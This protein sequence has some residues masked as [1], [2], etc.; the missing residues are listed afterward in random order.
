MPE[1]T[2]SDRPCDRVRSLRP[3]ASWEWA[4]L[5]GNGTHGAL[6]FGDPRAE[7]IIVNHERLY[8]PREHPG[9]P[10]DVAPYLPTLRHIV[11]EDG[12]AEG[13]V[14]L[15]TRACE[16]GLAPPRGNPAFHPAFSLRVATRLQG[17]VSHYR[18]ETDFRTGEV[19]VG[20]QDCRR[21]FQ[22][23]LFVSRDLDSV[24]LDL[25]CVGGA[26]FSCELTLHHGDHHGL[27]RPEIRARAQ[28][29]TTTVAY[30][31][32]TGGYD[33]AVR[34]AATDGRTEV[35]GD[36]IRIARARRALLLLRVRPWSAR[37]G[38]DARALLRSLVASPPSY[39]G[40]LQRHR[41]FHTR[42]YDRVAID[43]GGRRADREADIESLIGRC[44]RDGS[45]ALALLEKLYNAGRYM[46]LCCFGALPPNLQGVW[47]GTW[48]SPWGG[49]YVWDTNLQ[50]AIASALSCNMQE[51]WGAYVALIEGVVPFWKDNARRIGGCR[52][53]FA[54][55]A[56]CPGIHADGAEKHTY[57][58]WSWMFGA[59][60]AGWQ[61][62]LFYDG[63]L[64]TGDLEYLRK[65]VVPLLLE[66]AAFYEDWLFLD[67]T[68]RYR[69]S[70]ACS[71]EV[72]F[73][74]NPTFEIAVA[75]DVLSLLPESVAALRRAGVNEGL[76]TPAELR[77]WRA[78]RRKLPE[79]RINDAAHTAGP[80]DTRGYYI[81]RAPVPLEADGALKEFAIPNHREV[82]AHRHFSHLYPV[83]VSREFDPER[84][85]GLW[86]AAEI[87]LEK[88]LSHWVRGPR[89]NGATHGRMH[90]ALCA[91]EFG[92][93]D[94]AWEVLTTLATRGVV[95][96]SLMM[97]H[98]DDHRVFNVDG[99]GALPEVVN[100]MLVFA[101]PG[102]IRLLP[103]LPAQLP[104]GSVQGLRLRGRIELKR[105]EWDLHAGVIEAVVVS[106]VAQ[107]VTLS[108]GVPHG[109]SGIE[110]RRTDARST[111]AKPAGPRWRLK[112]NPGEDVAVRVQ[113]DRV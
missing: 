55:G 54:S 81:D 27:V 109:V 4:M 106:D 64:Y 98:F 90:A 95:F 82:Y 29:L 80:P 35:R 108:V 75:R 22:R 50:L 20:F 69:F 25:A 96:P 34:V 89:G 76:P 16:K 91:L 68:G 39:E 112:L 102:E 21:S 111:K 31:H 61:A 5:S 74:D 2:G 23:R 104:R 1:T 43:L 86:R 79:Y 92:R 26:G 103:G 19:T 7:T 73:A 105:L 85:P 24:V 28:G 53:V 84:T 45:L 41:A 11:R 100:R 87:A 47:S 44:E 93:G 83:F 110:T 36:R 113:L 99:N 14:F 52:G 67:D 59:G 57:G 12:Y 107:R 71:P 60:Y 40:L 88:R 49:G 13:L 63:W 94:V 58:H 33:G 38:S 46:S 32:G 65:H 101:R 70:P 72:G 8:L 30:L 48:D 37:Q 18:R 56:Y 97:S 78:M 17:E 62:R 15:D 10:L 66:V 51:L 6:V 77:R 42:L 9:D 3:A